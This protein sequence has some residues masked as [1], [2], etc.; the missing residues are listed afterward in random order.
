MIFC[1][2]IVN[3][4]SVANKCDTI[5]LFSTKKRNVKRKMKG[6][7]MDCNM[8]WH[9]II[10]TCSLIAIMCGLWFRSISGLIASFFS[11]VACSRSAPF[12]TEVYH[13][14]RQLHL[15]HPAGVW[16]V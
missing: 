5:V 6:S 13:C 16:H 11:V 4:K 8:C 14:M 7:K 10:Y 12:Q 1:F 15:W 9:G 2:S 3:K